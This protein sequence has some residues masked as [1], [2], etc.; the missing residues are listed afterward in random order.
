LRN[1]GANVWGQ[2]KGKTKMK[3]V[4]TGLEGGIEGEQT[5]GGEKNP[6]AKTSATSEK[7]RAD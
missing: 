2:K 4:E 5:V 6:K 1:A 7:N 3:A